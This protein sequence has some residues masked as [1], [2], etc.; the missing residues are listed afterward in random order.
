MHAEL[1]AYLTEKQYNKICKYWRIINKY[2]DKVEKST[3]RYDF[4]TYEQYSDSEDEGN[5]SYKEH[6]DNHNATVCSK[7]TAL[8]NKLTYFNDEYD[9]YITNKLHYKFHDDAY[10]ERLFQLLN[11][12]IIM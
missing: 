12:G 8:I 5:I 1:R 10:P 6:C 3:I 9:K 11:N 2:E 4:L 7:H